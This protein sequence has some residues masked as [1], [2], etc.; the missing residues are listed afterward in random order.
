M[1]P[2]E[3]NYNQQGQA[4]WEM[5]YGQQTE[6][7]SNIPQITEEMH[8]DI[9]WKDRALVKNLASDEGGFQYLQKKYPDLEFKK[10]A[11]R[12][13]MRKRGSQGN[14]N[15]LDP[16]GFDLQDISD[17]GVDVAQ[18][19]IEGGATAAGALAGGGVASIPAAIAAGGAAGAGTEALKQKIAQELGLRENI[20]GTDV[21]ISGAFGAASPL[22]FGAGAGAKQAAKAGLSEFAQ[23]GAL[24]TAKDAIAGKI[25]PQIA[26]FTSGVPKKVYKTFLNNTDEIANMT[27][28]DMIMRSV[29]V[30]DTI[31]EGAQ[32]LKSEL[33]E[34]Y[35]VLKESGQ[36]ID[37][38]DVHD[39]LLNEITR[40]SGKGTTNS[41]KEAARGLQ[42]LYEN[43]FTIDGDLIPVENVDFDMAM[44]IKDEIAARS[45]F[46]KN[47]GDLTPA[48]RVVGGKVKASSE[49][50]YSKTNKAIE[51]SINNFGPLKSKY[52]DYKKVEKFLN[53]FK[54]GKGAQADYGEKAVDALTKMDSKSAKQVFKNQNLKDIASRFGVDIEKEADIVRA[55]NMLKNPSFMPISGSATSTSR[56]LS[57]GALG[58]LAGSQY[59][60]G[61]GLPV[62]A[63]VG[64]GL[65]AGSPRAW[66]AYFKAGKGGADKVRNIQKMMPFNPQQR[67]NI[68][69][70]MAQGQRED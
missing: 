4:P 44:K 59:G 6:P 32:A 49:N 53:S 29:N 13:L 5:D 11:D 34:Q 33:G 51:S 18:G 3:E 19:V 48:Q 60:D 66:K 70:N 24:G 17:I 56:T 55:Y 22:L 67:A 35:N 45:Q 7:A 12:T 64:A 38:T 61:G 68:W 65:I 47:L 58:A 8:P 27:D 10:F 25:A 16:E 20:S 15:V 63:G 40:L 26:E 39:S 57:S 46:N 30:F 2:W 69:M 54:T 28:E 41:E 31:E 23:K 1:K 50:L 9:S 62:A 43:A 37:M 21:A 14:Y 52:A 42:E 36:A